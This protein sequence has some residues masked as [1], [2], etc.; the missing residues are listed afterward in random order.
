MSKTRI[1]IADDHTLFREGME[2]LINSTENFVL[3]AQAQNGQELLSLLHKYSGTGDFPDICLLDINMPELNGYETMKI[4]HEQF[5]QLP[6]LA[7][8]MLDADF[9]VLKMIHQ[10]AM[11]FLHKNCQKQELLDALDHLISGD[12]YFS[13]AISKAL[14]T[15]RRNPVPGLSDR[16]T[17]FLSY[18]HL[19]LS[20]KDIAE[21]MYVGE[22]TVHGYRDSLFSKL[23]V[24]TRNSLVA[25][26]FKT[27]I[28]S[29]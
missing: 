14:V 12:F 16:E 25:F 24:N 20:Y 2:L 7:L 4:I 13:K 28:I 10:G 3:S 17:E 15:A 11:G 9:S 26:A 1:I 23:N 5:P 18:C 21:R 27:G 19:D 6:V 8:S 22:R 29:E